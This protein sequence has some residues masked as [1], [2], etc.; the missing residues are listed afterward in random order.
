L[1]AGVNWRTY[2]PEGASGAVERIWISPDGRAMLAAVGAEDRGQA[3]RVLR[4][5]NGG[6]Y[7]D[8]L[9]ANLPPGSVY[10]VTA[11]A[12][13]GALYAATESGIYFTFNSLQAPAPAG[14]WM[15]LRS[16]L[17]AGAARDVV[18]D[19]S[20]HHLFAA[21]DG[22]GV[23]V[24]MAPHRAMA[25]QL[26]NAADFGMRSAAPGALLTLIGARLQ[27]VS[28]NDR[29]A[30]VLATAET[31]SQVQLPFDATGETM[32]VTLN[33]GA[34]DV[35]VGLPLRE[36]AP[37]ILVDREGTPM[38]LDAES[39]LQSDAGMPVRPGTRLQILATG[40]GRVEPEWPAGLAA[41]LQGS[42]KV[43]APVRVS[44]NGQP[45]VVTKAILAPGYIGF[46]LVEIEVPALL[47]AGP[48]ELW[49]EAAGSESNR[50]RVYVE[51]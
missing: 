7:W 49:V 47:D 24:A 31:E 28:A 14:N 16:G 43:V 20:G 13:T 17:P 26:A 45:A 50:V 35:Q 21:V 8:D 41:P 1:D 3:G 40:L 30:P 38:I 39:G 29:V 12:A 10:G 11:D 15:P 32:R 19:A 34:G 6:Q 25:P 9:T 23:F 18:L 36:A 48:A 4:S 44:L 2:E 5:L 51:Q 46:Y 42:P 37:A 27:S 22:F 33:W